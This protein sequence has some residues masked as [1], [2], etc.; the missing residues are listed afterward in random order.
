M[1]LFRLPSIFVFSNCRM[2]WNF[3]VFCELMASL[4]ISTAAATEVD[5]VQPTCL[6][7]KVSGRC[8]DLWIAIFQP[9]LET[10]TLKINRYFKMIQVPHNCYQLYHNFLSIIG[11]KSTVSSIVYW[12]SIFE[13]S[14][15]AIFIE[16]IAFMRIERANIRSRYFANY[17]P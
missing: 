9:I 11:S 5:F 15:Y 3:E 13:V 10:S 7:I 1:L 2:F 14:V 8:N 12:F 17:P 4:S 16:I 6:L